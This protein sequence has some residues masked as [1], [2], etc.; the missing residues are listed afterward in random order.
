[1]QH[2][3]SNTHNIP[4]TSHFANAGLSRENAIVVECH[5]NERVEKWL[6]EAGFGAD[7]QYILMMDALESMPPTKVLPAEAFIS[8]I[9]SVGDTSCRH[10]LESADAIAPTAQT[11]EAMAYSTE[12]EFSASYADLSPA[13]TP[14]AA[15]L[16][17]TVPCH[18]PHP[19]A[20]HADRA[21]KEMSSAYAP[22]VSDIPG[23]RYDSTPRKSH[24]L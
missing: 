13:P 9:L 12:P 7:L 17:A 11:F 4:S 21:T 24:Q 1:M 5:S 20:S 6:P 2:P 16:D 10:T 14:V 18:S 8:E 22:P 15:T 19:S 23:P 3:S